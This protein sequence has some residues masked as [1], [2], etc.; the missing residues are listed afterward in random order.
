MVLF[1]AFGRT[2]A[3]QFGIQSIPSGWTDF[4]HWK[5]FVSCEKAIQNEIGT[6]YSKWR[7]AKMNKER[8]KFHDIQ[9]CLREFPANHEMLTRNVIPKHID[10]SLRVKK[11][12]MNQ[13]FYNRSHRL[14]IKNRSRDMAP[15]NRTIKSSMRLPK[16]NAFCFPTRN[17]SREQQ[18]TAK[19]P[20][21]HFVLCMIP[22]DAHM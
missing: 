8:L 21:R 7:V 14:A 17:M 12:P 6:C 11:N 1:L 4:V 18:K 20:S 5:Y 13:N 15:S 22:V 2:P 10:A 16:F 3:N 9:G 19:N